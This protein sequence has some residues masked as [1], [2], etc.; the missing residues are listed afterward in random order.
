MTVPGE[1]ST[2]SFSSWRRRRCS[3]ACQNRDAA[4]ARLRRARAVDGAQGA[5]RSWT[6]PARRHSAFT[7]VQLPKLA[8]SPACQR[9]GAGAPE[10]AVHHKRT[11]NMIVHQ[12]G[13]TLA[14][15]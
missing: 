7:G 12:G 10:R 15:S 8:Q 2:A 5:W 6:S 13:S 9:R 4:R 11:R 1:V 3:C 14:S